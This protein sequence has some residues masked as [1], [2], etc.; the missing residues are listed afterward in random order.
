MNIHEIKD[1]YLCGTLLLQGFQL[2]DQNRENGFTVFSFEDTEN[3]RKVISDY[4]L[5]KLKVD[6]S[7]YGLTLRQ[8]KGLMHN[9]SLVSTQTMV[10]NNEF[11]YKKGTK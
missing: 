7:V 5:G 6:P 2:V 11:N 9:S 8:L 10:N 4:Y 3:L 1:F